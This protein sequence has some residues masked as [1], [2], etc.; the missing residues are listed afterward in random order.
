M[1]KFTVSKLIKFATRS[2]LTLG[3]L[4]VLSIESSAQEDSTS[5]TT[6]WAFETTVRNTQLYAAFTGL[7]GGYDGIFESSLNEDDKDLVLTAIFD[8]TYIF[9]YLEEMEAGCEY[10]YSTDEEKLDVGILGRSLA[11]SQAAE[12]AVRNELLEETL[13]LL[14]TRARD[15]ANQIVRD[16][17]RDAIEFSD[18]LSRQEMEQQ[19]YLDPDS[20]KTKYSRWCPRI[21]ELRERL[22]AGEFKVYG[23]NTF[24][25]Q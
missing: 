2:I 15:R 23:E 10:Y 25:V 24:T 9:A 12:L 4:W 21:A 14:S 19:A 18:F 16:F 8:T 1:E 5:D 20:M 13:E 17:P 11:D 6:I 22:E 3:W 7:W